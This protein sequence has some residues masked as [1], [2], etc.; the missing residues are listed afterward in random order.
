MWRGEKKLGSNNTVTFT[1]VAGLRNAHG[2]DLQ[3]LGLET[4]TGRLNG[5]VCAA[6]QRLMRPQTGWFHHKCQE[7][8][9]DGSPP[10]LP[11]RGAL[12]HTRSARLPPHGLRHHHQEPA[13]G[14]GG[15]GILTLGSQ[16]PRGSSLPTSEFI[17]YL[18]QPPAHPSTSARLSPSF[19]PPLHPPSC[20][21]SSNYQLVSPSSLLFPLR[22]Q[23]LPSSPVC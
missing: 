16:S 2:A 10:S 9:S 21:S 1:S 20:F 6:K 17:L 5:R 14:S 15:C 22:S 3:T 12:G 23:L 18:T 8:Q 13:Q 7:L 19:L 4:G 11:V